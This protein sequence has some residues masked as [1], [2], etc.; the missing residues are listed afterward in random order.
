LDGQTDVSLEQFGPFAD[1]FTR[2]GLEVP[3][4]LELLGLQNRGAQV[5]IDRIEQALVRSGALRFV[6]P[7]FDDPNWRPHLV[8]AIA[9]ILDDGE[10]LD[11]GSLWRA[12]DGG[13]WVIPQ[14]VVTA[15]MVDRDFPTRLVERVESLCPVSVHPG[16]SPVERHSATGPANTIQR[17]AKLLAS[18]LSVG[19]VLPS[20]SSWIPGVREQPT[21]TDLLKQDRDDAASI[22]AAWHRQLVEQFSLRGRTL[23][24]KAA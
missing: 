22:A 1:A 23:K 6:D 8:G 20:L 17:S 12:I 24:P 16:L 11:V 21:V 5:V 14:L 13:S 2:A 15:L 18:L 9:L 7:L 10:H 3:G 4:Y 19:A